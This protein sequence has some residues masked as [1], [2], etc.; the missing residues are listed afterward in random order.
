MFPVAKCG[1]M[2]TIACISCIEFVIDFGLGRKS[3]S[4]GLNFLVNLLEIL[5]VILLKLT[6][7]AVSSSFSL[8]GSLG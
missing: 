8:L 2:C 5:S 1:V 3:N 6:N 4:M 7:D